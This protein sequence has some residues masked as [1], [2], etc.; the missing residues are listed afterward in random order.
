MKLTITQDFTYWHNGCN[1]A[2]YVAGQEVD[3]DDQEMI[4]VALAEGWAVRETSAH[5]SAPETSA[6]HAEPDRPKRGRKP[7][8]PDP[9]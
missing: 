9:A 2:D 6:M 1:R 4:A 5:F 8:Q 7:K 3:A